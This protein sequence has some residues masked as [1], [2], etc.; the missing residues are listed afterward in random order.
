[1][2]SEQ[3]VTDDAE[4]KAASQVE[5][6]LIDKGHLNEELVLKVVEEMIAEKEDDPEEQKVLISIAHDIYKETME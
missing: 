5:E 6:D 4:E 1:M 2:Y 3:K